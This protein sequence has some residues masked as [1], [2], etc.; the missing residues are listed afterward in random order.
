MTAALTNK[1]FSFQPARVSV[2]SSNTQK[3]KRC[4]ALNAKQIQLLTVEATKYYKVRR[5]R[6][7]SYRK[8]DRAMRPIYACPKKF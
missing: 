2:M 7:L 4:T 1:Q 3:P 5:T 8:E 6:Q